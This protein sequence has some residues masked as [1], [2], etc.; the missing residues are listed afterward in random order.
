MADRK[1]EVTVNAAV[2]VGTA[3]CEN[4]ATGTFRVSGGLAEVIDAGATQW[5]RSWRRPRAAPSRRSRSRTRRAARCCSR[6]TRKHR[7]SSAPV[8]EHTQEGR[9][10]VEQ[11]D[12]RVAVITGG[13]SGIGEGLAQALPCRRHE[14]GGLRHRAGAGRACRRGGGG[15]W[16]ARRLRS[17]SDV[18]DQASVYSL[19]DQA[20][21]AY[22]AVHLVCSNA[23]VLTVGPLMETSASDWQWLLNVNL[24]GAIH[25]ANTFVPR[26][27]A[28]GGERTSP[29]PRRWPGRTLPT[30]WRSAP[31][32]LRSTRWSGMPRCFAS[33][34]P[35]RALASRCSAPALSRP[36]IGESS[37]NRPAELGGPGAPES[38]NP[39][40][41][42][43]TAGGASPGALAASGGRSHPRGGARQPEVHLLAPGAPGLRRAAAPRADGSLRR[44][45][46]AAPS[47]QPASRSAVSPAAARARASR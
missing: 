25:S 14:A 9:R 18:T 33:S 17:G 45:R 7:A 1:L 35:R 36:R 21:E 39:G 32:P 40:G 11:L 26:M 8:S 5:R 15:R 19:A 4:L 2:C 12:G 31:T 10:M 47:P 13:G 24:F 41:P 30:T 23:G 29:S 34:S 42:G 3:Q 22:G 16:A 27:R 44:G 6:P 37:R 38:A 28:Q 20:Y 46:V 43:G